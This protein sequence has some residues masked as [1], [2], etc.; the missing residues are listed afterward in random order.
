MRGLERFPDAGLVG[1]R[2]YGPA[3]PLPDAP[4]QK[5]WAGVTRSHGVVADGKFVMQSNIYFNTGVGAGKLQSGLR[6]AADSGY[7]VSGT[8]MGTAL[9]EF[10]HVVTADRG[11]RREVYDHAV[12]QADAAGATPRHYITRHVSGYASS[13]MGEFSAEIF[14]DVME[15]GSGASDLSKSSF[16]I[17]EGAG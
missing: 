5:D 14:A 1:V 4:G 13:D 16:A 2:T 10:G 6:E 11:T 15:H 12:A 17:I 9:H 3:R 7:L 8:H